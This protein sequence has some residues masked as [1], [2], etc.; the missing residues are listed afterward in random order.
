[1]PK[2]KRKKLTYNEMANYIVQLEM[3]LNNAINTIGQSVADYIDYNNDKEKF[4]GFLEKKYD[5]KFER[6]EEVSNRKT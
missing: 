5:K 1:M 4:I 3:K 2:Q 6:T